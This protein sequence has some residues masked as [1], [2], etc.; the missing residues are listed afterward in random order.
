MLPEKPVWM[1]QEDYDKQYGNIKKDVVKEVPTATP[2]DTTH[3]VQAP[4]H[5][6][7]DAEAKPAF[8][9]HK[10]RH[11]RYDIEEKRKRVE[12]QKMREEQ[13]KKHEIEMTA[14]RTINV[15]QIVREHYNE[16]T[17][18][19]N[20]SKRNLS[21]IIKLRN[22][23]N[24][25]KFM[26]IEKYT[27]KG[28]VVLELA[29]GK[30]GDLRK[31]GNVGISQFIGIDISNASIQEAHKRYRSMKN[32]DYQVILITG[33]CFGESLGVAVEPFPECRFPCD[34][35]STQFCLHYAFE[36][37]EKA[38]RALLNVSKSLK[39]GGYFFGTIPDS[40][41]IRYKLNKFGTD[42]EKPGW[43]NSIYRVKFENNEYQKN[44][45]EFPSPYGQM[46][47][48]WLE[49][50]IDNVPEYVVPFETLRS[51]ADE[52]GMELELQLPFNKF[53]VQEIPH[54][55]NRFS[56]RMMEGLQRSDGKF[57]VEGE[58]KEAASY[59]YTMFAFRKVRNPVE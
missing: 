40:E 2:A 37:E 23:N 5:P 17:M 44:G 24:A 29:C 16:R 1:S 55:I 35:V 12:V 33:D 49:D 30:G 36:A 9:I 25:I 48:Y 4:D 10:R 20:R 52:Y 42:V 34:V 26:L 3:L 50:A 8:K 45:Y 22:F 14:N 59:F 21:P 57:G 31:Y 32:L 18:I 58:E 15:D 56:P 53:F 41:F 47:T 39:I 13:F 6:E 19:A 11:H 46:Y 38:R 43:E 27:K 28:D 51:L 54:W 7:E